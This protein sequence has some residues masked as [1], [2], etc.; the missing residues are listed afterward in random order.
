[1]GQGEWRGR[2]CRLHLTC[3]HV[4][5]KTHAGIQHAG[6]VTR[7]MGWGLPYVP[8]GYWVVSQVAVVA[9]TR[10]VLAD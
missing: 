10:G 4:H 9:L 2:E 7:V 5:A 3:R 1:M 6:P 8:G